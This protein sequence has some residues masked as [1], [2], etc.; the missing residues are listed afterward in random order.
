MLDK[1]LWEFGGDTNASV[2]ANIPRARSAHAPPLKGEITMAEKCEK[3]KRKDK[4][5]KKCIE[6][7]CYA[8]AKLNIIVKLELNRNI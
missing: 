8:N 2:L 5:D 1:D 3:C 6:L 4:R 7:C